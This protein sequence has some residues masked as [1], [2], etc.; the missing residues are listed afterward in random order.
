MR[1]VSS[2]IRER[3][4]LLAGLVA[5]VT[6]GA[7]WCSPSSAEKPPLKPPAQKP[8]PPESPPLEQ[9]AK[10]KSPGSCTQVSANVIS[11]A[12]G[13]KHV[14][15]LRNGCDKPV[16][17]QVWTDVDPSPRHV[18]RAAKGALVEAITRIG[19]PAREFKAFKECR[20]L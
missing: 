1:L 12:Y 20:Y 9:P 19:S 5:A 8:P 13:Y 18:L 7:L 17:C 3:A 11:E 6:I 16:E 10:D 15:S 14:V 4:R 2:S